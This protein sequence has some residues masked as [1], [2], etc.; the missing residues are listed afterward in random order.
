MSYVSP[1]N[2]VSLD[3]FFVGFFMPFSLMVYEYSGI[4]I[5]YHFQAIIISCPCPFNNISKG[6]M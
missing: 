5:P 6:E 4:L 1:L 3:E 2:Y